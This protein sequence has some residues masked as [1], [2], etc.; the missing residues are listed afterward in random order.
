MVHSAKFIVNRKAYNCYLQQLDIRNY[1]Y[2]VKRKL[3]S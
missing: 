3:Q 1:L 2:I